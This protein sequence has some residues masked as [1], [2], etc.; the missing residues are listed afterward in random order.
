MAGFIVFCDG[1][2]WSAAGWAFDAAIE[3][4]CSILHESAEGAPLG[5][6]L[7]QQQCLEEGYSM[8]DLRELTSENQELCHRAIGALPERT[9][10]KGPESW[11]QPELFESWLEQVDLLL[12]MAEAE[13]RGEAPSLLNPHMRELVPPTKRKSGPGW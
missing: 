8:I 9:R 12:R 4:L 11:A 1:R 10:K 6:W 3:S 2:A 13:R 5:E 7:L